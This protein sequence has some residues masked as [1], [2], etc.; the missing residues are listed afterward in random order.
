MTITSATD[1]DFVVRTFPQAIA[2]KCWIGAYKDTQGPDYKNPLSGWQGVTGE[3]WAYTHWNSSEPNGGVGAPH[4]NYIQFSLDGH[5]N[6]ER[7]T[8][9]HT[10]NAA[11]WYVVE[12]E[13]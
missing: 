5:W 13:P 3:P 2:N 8:P 7:N 12:F 4:S 11:R 6:D 1:S 9:P 10:I